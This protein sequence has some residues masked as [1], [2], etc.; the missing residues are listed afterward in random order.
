MTEPTLSRGL[1][2]YQLHD[3]RS[4]NHQADLAPKITTM[5]H[6]VHGLPLDQGSVGSCTAE[7]LI[8][9]LM[10][11]PDFK[12]A[13]YTQADAYALYHD[14]TVLEGQPYPPNDPGGSGLEV[15][16]AAKN[17]GL[18]KS[19]KHA[20]GVQNGL[21]ALMLRPI[22]TGIPWFDSFFH[23]DANGI[24]HLGGQIVGGHEIVAFG[25]DAE[26]Q[27]VWF[28]NSWGPSW[29]LGGKFAMP[30]SVWDAVLRQGGD[31]TIPVN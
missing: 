25:I 10:I 22:I 8:G 27:L 24:I 29:G 15:C 18:I 2:R 20:F 6:A 1:G 31:I 28:M 21:K 26:Q 23:P 17:K 16:K 7:A 5:Q 13:L 19:Y 9:A 3:G 12:G 4:W 11:G 30:W 14:E